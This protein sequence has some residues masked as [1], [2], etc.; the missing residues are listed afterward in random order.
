MPAVSLS[1]S[2][3]NLL[4]RANVCSSQACQTAAKLIL[5]DLDLNVD[6]CDDF[7]Q[8]SCV[9]TFTDIRNN[10]L[11]SLQALLEG[12]YED[13]LTGKIDPAF[14]NSTEKEQDQQNFN[15]LKMF[16]NAC[17][18][19]SSIDSLGP[20]PIF[21]YISRVFNSLGYDP[22]TEDER[23]G[24]QHVR[25]LTDTVIEMTTQGVE[26]LVSFYVGADD[27][28]PDQYVISINQPGLT[29]PSREYY[30]QQDTMEKYRQGLVAVLGAVLHKGQNELMGSSDIEGMVDRFIEFET[31]LAGITLPIEELQDPNAIYNPMTLTELHQSY[32]WIDW[33]RVLRNFAPNDVSLPEHVIVT[34]PRYLQALSSWL[35]ESQ[36]RPDGASTQALREFFST[37]VIL[38]NM[39]NIDQ[40]TREVYRQTIGLI[41]TGATEAQPRGRE[42]V[43]STSAAFGQLLGRYF[44]MKSFGGEPEREKVSDFINQILNA[45]TARLTQST[46]LDA[47]T[48]T[49]AI[50]KVKK[51]GH[52][53][54]YSIVSPDDRSPRSLDAFYADIQVKE[55]DYFGNQMSVYQSGFRKDWNQIGKVMNKDEWYMTPHEVNA[56][57][58]PNFNKVVIP[59]GIL[60]TPFYNTEV[61]NYLNYGG[62]GAVIGHE[63]THAFDNSGRL[64]DGEGFLNSWWTDAT[65]AAFEDKSQCFI[66]Q[67]GN[68]SVQG[69]DTTY[70]VNGKMTLGENL[71]DNGGVRAAYDAMTKDDMGLPGLENFTAEQLFFINYGR[72]W[73]TKMRPEMSVQRVRTDV[74]SPANVR[75]NGAVQNSVE[76]AKAFQCKEKQA[77]NPS[78]KC[79]IW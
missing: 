54:A 6:P 28:H 75:V 7:Y 9:G 32:P 78:D 47:E 79:Q 25:V 50:E 16:Y 64:Y 49:R 1:V 10:N 62:I 37:K 39:A 5:N 61:P 26:S 63:I 12:K 36:N 29:L 22:Q 33:F 34:S 8:Y 40:A 51:I 21:P 52:Q 72:V 31:H 4:A 71:A 73:C 18:D 30:T 53:E 55:K 20:T 65:S 35:L 59:A 24:P 17:M 15:K 77:M 60:Q 11:D 69:P 58:T 68:F 66:K 13:V 45:W 44:V 57:Y 56:Y 70:P 3:A 67:Y 46:W 2:S 19:Q 23:L 74:H 41:T 48:K 76:F 27:R 38:A 43:A 14:L 42:C